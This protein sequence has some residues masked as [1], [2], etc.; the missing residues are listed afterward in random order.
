MEDIIANPKLTDHAQ[1]KLLEKRE[2]LRLLNN[3]FA[4]MPGE[5]REQMTSMMQVGVEAMRNVGGEESAIAEAEFKNR[6][7]A[8]R[9]ID[10][11]LR[12]KTPLPESWFDDTGLSFLF[13]LYKHLRKKGYS[14][15]RLTS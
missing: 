3:L 15:E 9:D 4:L 1:F 7:D 11:Y 14:H 12:G 13:E 5:K 10:E 8:I 6:M 2:R